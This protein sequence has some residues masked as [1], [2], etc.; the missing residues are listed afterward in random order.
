MR[1]VR[2][3]GGARTT[4]STP[5]GARRRR[6]S[7]DDTVFC[8]RYLERPRH[9]EIQLLADAARRRRGARR[10]RVLG[11][12]PPPEGARGVALAGA[13]PELRARD[14][15]GGGRVR[16]RDRR[17]AAPA[18][19]SS[20]STA[21]DFFFL[22]LNGRI[23]VEHPVTE[24]VTGLDLV[25]AAA[26]ELAAGELA[27][28]RCRARAAT[29]SRCG[30]TRRTRARSFRRPA[31]S[32]GCGCRRGIRVDAGVEEGD[33]VGIAYDPMIAKLIAH[34]ETRDEALDRLAGALA[35]TE[36]EGVITNLPV[37]ALARRAPVR[38]R[39]RHD[40]GVPR[41]SIRR[42][43]P[44]PRA[45]AQPAVARLVPAQPAAASAP[46]R[47]RTSTSGAAGT[48]PARST[49]RSS[50]RCPAP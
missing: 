48:A 7:G 40:D 11:A 28:L 37:P 38:A 14:E 12:A 16:A 23:Q 30:S 8:E 3:A 29:R 39:G 20:C 25:A 18:P 26:R 6:R 5:H 19:P 22:E 10:A 41:S 44:P 36:V 15:R 33:E 21:R 24:L 47:R 43:R 2:S 17:T 46:R 34:G 31:G 45:P 32:S 4:R 50:R 35:E 27:D 42:C 1:V 13:R 49:A 9:V